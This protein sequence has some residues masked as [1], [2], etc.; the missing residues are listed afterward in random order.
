MTNQKLIIDI[1][2]DLQ[3]ILRDL[4]SI[5]AGRSNIVMK[6]D[7]EPITTKIQEVLQKL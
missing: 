7:L 4:K 3:A 1:K 2:N 5:L 6:I